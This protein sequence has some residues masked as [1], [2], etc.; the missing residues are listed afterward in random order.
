VEGE[1]RRWERGVQE[2]RCRPWMCLPGRSR[3]D[4]RGERESESVRVRE[5]ERE[6]KHAQSRL[7]AVDMQMHAAHSIGTVHVHLSTQPVSS[8]PCRFP[9][10]LQLSVLFFLLSLSLS[11]FTLLSFFSC[12]SSEYP[13]SCYYYTRAPVFVF[14][15]LHHLPP[16]TPQLTPKLYSTTL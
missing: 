16:P 15:I 1:W 9:L 4:R 2:E 8:L 7:T 10:P 5:R 13:L 12:C 6:K 3:E 11:L 14:L